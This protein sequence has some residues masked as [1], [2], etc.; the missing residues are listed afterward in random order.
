MAKEEKETKGE[1]KKEA[2]HKGAEKKEEKK[3]GAKKK[4]HLH[5]ILTTQAH[6]G[7][8]IHEHTYKDK[9]DDVHTRPAVFAG[10]SQSMDDLH[11]H[12][13]DHFGPQAGGGEE[14]GGEGGG[15]EEEEQPAA[16]AAPGQ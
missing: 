5:Q 6:D 15:G 13:D 3:G 2:E 14:P 11:S 12:M 16:G 9:K 8:F 4:L 7:S 1:A 10:T